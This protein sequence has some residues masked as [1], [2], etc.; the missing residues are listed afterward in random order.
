M[1]EATIHILTYYMEHHRVLQEDHEGNEFQ[2]LITFFHVRYSA[3]LQQI[4]RAVC[5]NV[6]YQGNQVHPNGL[7]V[8][9]Q[10]SGRA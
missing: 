8:T 1:W 2:E 3:L 10:T 6:A 9:F 4:S 7:E 5:A